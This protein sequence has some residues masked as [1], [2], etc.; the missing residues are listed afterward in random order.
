[1]HRVRGL[2]HLTST[3]KNSPEHREYVA[4]KHAQA[5]LKEAILNGSA[6]EN[7]ARWREKLWTTLV[8]DYQV[9]QGI[10]DWVKRLLRAF[11]EGSEQHEWSDTSATSTI[12]SKL[13]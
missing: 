3:Y 6:A 7:P 1:M 4:A 9:E 12:V 5:E 13:T 8:E 11:R 10:E 2:R